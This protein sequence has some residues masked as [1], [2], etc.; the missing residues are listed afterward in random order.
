MLR[1]GKN[2]TAP[3]LTGCTVQQ[4]EPATMYPLI[5][6]HAIQASG[7]GKASQKEWHRV[8]LEG[9]MKARN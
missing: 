8:G 7:R 1:Y 5:R 6:D 9:A 3:A 4:V 2:V